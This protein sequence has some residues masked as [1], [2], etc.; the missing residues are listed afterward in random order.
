MSNLKSESD[1]FDFPKKPKMLR[2][3]SS[4][5]TMDD[6]CVGGRGYKEDTIKNMEH[7]T[8][9]IHKT[10]KSEKNQISFSI[11]NILQAAYTQRPNTI[12]NN[13]D[14]RRRENKRLDYI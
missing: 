4:S 14:E 12:T 6:Q 11:T 8:S 1:S 13:L 2:V 10:H 5:M 7:E 9:K 3:A